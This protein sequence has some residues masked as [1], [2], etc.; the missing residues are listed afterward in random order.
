M[1]KCSVDGWTPIFANA[2][3]KKFGRLD[4]INEIL[5]VAK[6]DYSVNQAVNCWMN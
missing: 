1:K 6:S 4:D 2:R 5:N 3:S